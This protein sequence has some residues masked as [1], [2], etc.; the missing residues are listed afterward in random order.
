MR[1]ILPYFPSKIIQVFAGKFRGDPHYLFYSLRFSKMAHPL[2]PAGVIIFKRKDVKIRMEKTLVSIAPMLNPSEERMKAISA[3][4]HMPTP[5]VND[6]TQENFNSLAIP[7]ALIICPTMQAEVRMMI[8][9][10]P[11]VARKSNVI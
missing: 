8:N 9:Q 1:S 3:R 11:D 5:T 6:S 4:P 7:P 10:I 2:R